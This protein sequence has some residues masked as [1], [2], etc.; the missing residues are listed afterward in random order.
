MKARTK[1][2]KEVEQLAKKLPRITKPQLEYAREK[3]FKHEAV[4]LKSGKMTCLDCGHSWQ[5]K[6]PELG[7][8]ILG[9][10]CPSCNRELTVKQTRKKN[11]SAR[12]Y[13]QVIT[14]FKGYQLIRLYEVRK[15]WRSGQPQSFSVIRLYERWMNDKGQS[16]IRG[17]YVTSKWNECWGGPYELRSE[18]GSTDYTHHLNQDYVYPK[19]KFIPV[20]KRNG[21]RTSI[22]DMNPHLL[23]YKLLKDPKVETL[24]KAKQ[25]SLARLYLNDYAQKY[26]DSIKI[27]LRNNYIVKDSSM[28]IDYLDLLRYFNKDLRNA[29]YVCPEN[30]HA[31]HDRLVKKKQAIRDAKTLKERIKKAKRDAEIYN[32]HR[33]KYMGLEFTKGDL[34]ISFI[35]SP[36]QLAEESLSLRH[37]AFTNGYHKK[38]NVLMFSVR[39]KGAVKATAAVNIA[40]KK[41]QE[42]R[43]QNN[44]Q[45]EHDTPENRK[46]GERATKLLQDNM[47]TILNGGKKPK[48]KPAKKTKKSKV[49][50]LQLAS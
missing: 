1:L 28:W 20:L 7:Y 26:W 44:W 32:K 2:Q 8:K 6:E 24:V 16:V 38:E 3:L 35:N 45:S 13:Y 4:L 18:R 22:H 31:E 12:N 36:Q 48:K 21:L 17:M 47:I 19:K 14:V 43:G 46:L 42:L 41:V 34:T 23:F 37:C 5:N 11:F 39:V 40:G 15:W 27:C 29:K 25:Y 30:L 10:T 49:R 33:A 9:V 50:K